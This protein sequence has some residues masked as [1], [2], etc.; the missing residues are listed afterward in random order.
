MRRLLAKCLALA[1]LLL[2]SVAAHGHHHHHGQQSDG[3]EDH[4]HH[5]HRQLGGRRKSCGTQV[6]LKERVLMEEAQETW[7]NKNRDRARHLIEGRMVLSVQID[8]YMHV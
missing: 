1:L 3:S 7:N 5:A 2:P 4:H 6:S 8:V